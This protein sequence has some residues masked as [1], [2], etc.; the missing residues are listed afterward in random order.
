MSKRTITPEQHFME[1][2]RR[3]IQEERFIEADVAERR[4][5]A[6]SAKKA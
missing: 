6:T 4:A 2:Y 1:S 3:Y 5:R